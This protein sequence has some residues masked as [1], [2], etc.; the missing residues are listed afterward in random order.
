MSVITARVSIPNFYIGT[1]GSLPGLQHARQEAKKI[2]IFI[3]MRLT[4]INPAK[5]NW[6]SAKNGTLKLF[7]MAGYKTLY[8][9]TLMLERFMCSYAMN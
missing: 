7:S 2:P 8:N 1:P 4:A 5:Q 9:N 3:L 6:L